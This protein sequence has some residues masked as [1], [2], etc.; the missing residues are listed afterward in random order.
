MKPITSGQVRISSYD[1]D[2]NGLLYLV[3]GPAE[4]PGVWHVM[5]ETGLIESWWYDGIEDDPVLAE[6]E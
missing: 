4:K 1:V 3:L 2:G 5:R 6:A